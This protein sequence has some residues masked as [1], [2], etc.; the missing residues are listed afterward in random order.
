MSAENQ[1]NDSTEP[2][3][4]IDVGRK[5]H[6]THFPVQE[7][8]FKDYGQENDYEWVNSGPG[9]LKRVLKKLSTILIRK[10]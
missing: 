10:K 8:H 2:K 4:P 3:A 9:R 6:Q 5:I 1:S 7:T